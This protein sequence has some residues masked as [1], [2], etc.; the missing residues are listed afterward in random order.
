MSAEKQ[1]NRVTGQQIDLFDLDEEPTISS[2]TPNTA[3]ISPSEVV[4][5]NEPSAEEV[6]A[7]YDSVIG[8]I[9]YFLSMDEQLEAIKN[10]EAHRTMLRQKAL[11]E[12]RQDMRDTYRR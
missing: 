5:S 8:V 6:K 3:E 10:P 2:Q 11:A 7:S 12:D 9:P 4:I 1:N